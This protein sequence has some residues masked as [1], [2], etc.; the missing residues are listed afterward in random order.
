MPHQCVRCGTFYDDGAKEI[1]KG[2][3]CGAKLFFYVKKE[4]LE[5]AKEIAANLSKVE[6]KKIEK[7]V[8]EIMGRD[9]E[10]EK[11]VILDLESIRIIKPGKFE[12]DLVHLF[13]KKNPLVFKLDEG[14]YIID[15]AES[16]KRLG[17]IK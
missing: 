6:K 13:N 4:R 1:L 8:Y 3:N 14:K 11:P 12:L 2:C 10:E 5:Q 17:E 16:F 7:D 15:I 9:E